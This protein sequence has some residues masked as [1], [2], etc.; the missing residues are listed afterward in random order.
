MPCP[1]QATRV[2]LPELFALLVGLIGSSWAVIF[3]VIFCWRDFQEMLSV[4]FSI[5]I[6]QISTQRLTL[7]ERY[8]QPIGAGIMSVERSFEAMTR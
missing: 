4:R 2:R 8:D 1:R 6:P 5:L 3:H 7:G